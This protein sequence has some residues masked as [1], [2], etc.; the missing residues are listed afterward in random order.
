MSSSSSRGRLLKR[1]GPR[2]GERSAFWRSGSLWRPLSG[3]PGLPGGT[4]PS[5]GTADGRD[6]LDTRR[7][8]DF[9]GHPDFEE[10]HWAV[11]GEVQAQV[12]GVEMW[13]EKVRNYLYMA[14]VATQRTRAEDDR[15]ARAEMM[16]VPVRVIPATQRLNQETSTWPTVQPSMEWLTNTIADFG[17]DASGLWPC[18][19]AGASRY[20]DSACQDAGSDQPVPPASGREADP[21]DGRGDEALVQGLAGV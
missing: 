4:P 17:M 10:A 7:R 16:P 18:L 12:T 3:R 11:L 21:L 2:L 6:L 20:F 13:L 19:A 8:D 9:S 15:R 5:P 1:T 14:A